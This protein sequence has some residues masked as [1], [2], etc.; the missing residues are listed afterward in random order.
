MQSIS[1]QSPCGAATCSAA[2]LPLSTRWSC[3]YPHIL[4]SWAAASCFCVLTVYVSL[5]FTSNEI[6]LRPI[7]LLFAQHWVTIR[8]N[9]NLI[10][11]A[12]TITRS[13]SQ[14]G[15]RDELWQ[16]ALT[17]LME[18]ADGTDTMLYTHPPPDHTTTRPHHLVPGYKLL[19]RVK[20]AVTV[21]HSRAVYMS[22][23]TQDGDN[24]VVSIRFNKEYDALYISIVCDV[25]IY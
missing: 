17:G 3:R 4:F 22:Y 2:S 13:V 9:Q 10:S 21:R 15:F 5:I 25:Y 23:H 7:T 16:W 20:R 11:Q 8:H 14:F 6:R 1:F 18:R 12:N 19:E 24:S